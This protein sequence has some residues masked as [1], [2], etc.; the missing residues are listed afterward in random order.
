M[1]AADGGGHPAKTVLDLAVALGRGDRLAGIA[2]RRREP[3]AFRP[4]ASE[5]T[6]SPLVDM[7]A[8]DGHG[9]WAAINAARS[10]VRG[11]AWQRACVHSSHHGI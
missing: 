8:V 10:T 11:V 7:P 1:A 9:P 4:V 3:G 2:M 5:L 6:A